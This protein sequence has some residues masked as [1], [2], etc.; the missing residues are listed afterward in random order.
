M[1]DTT[2][3]EDYNEPTRHRNRVRKVDRTIERIV[4]YR[5]NARE[6]LHSPDPRPNKVLRSL[7]K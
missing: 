3:W 6:D 7:I 1:I 2:N 5:L 4:F